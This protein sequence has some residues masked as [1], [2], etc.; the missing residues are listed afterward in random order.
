MRLIITRHGETI[1][2]INRVMQGHLPGTLSKLGIEQAKKLAL[3]LK[4][5]KIDIICSSDLARSADTAK[6][7]MKFYPNVP[8]H[9]V[10]E[11][12]ERNLGGFTGKKEGEVDWNNKPS[13]V[14]ELSHM[15]KRAKKF[16]DEIYAKHPNDSILFVGHAGINVILT[17]V[18]LNKEYSVEEY[19]QELTKQG[20]TVVSIFEI[21]ED[22][23]NVAH[24]LHCTKHLA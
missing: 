16:L 22:K 6:E 21:K 19:K 1:E 15:R 17:G 4:D 7:I 13:D 11:L 23:N 5:E 12:R 10:K 24:L 8:V 18:I 2:N 9:F 14:E 3:R 20:N